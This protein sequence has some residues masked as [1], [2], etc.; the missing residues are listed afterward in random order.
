MHEEESD[1]ET[2]TPMRLSE[3]KRPNDSTRFIIN[4]KNELDSLQVHQER[5]LRPALSQLTDHIYIPKFLAKR[6]SPYFYAGETDLTYHN[7]RSFQ[8]RN[9]K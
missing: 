7:Y 3:D 1:S 4:F 2:L 5:F 6:F 8:T 9:L